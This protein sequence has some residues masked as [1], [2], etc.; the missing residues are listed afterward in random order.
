[1]NLIVRHGPAPCDT[2]DAEGVLHSK[3]T[4]FFVLSM[5]AADA[6]LAFGDDPK[7]L[8]DLVRQIWAHATKPAG[9]GGLGEGHIL[10]GS[11]TGF[12]YVVSS[13]SCG[14][15]TLG[16][17]DGGLPFVPKN[18]VPLYAVARYKK[19]ADCEDPDAPEFID[20]GIDY[21]GTEGPGDPKN[22][23]PTVFQ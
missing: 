5:T 16:V 6:E 17:T 11:Y 23:R 13:S 18:Y 2:E 21:R 8:V 15:E 3:F 10:V 19:P 7:P 22:L 1:M 9:E 12:E 14:G 4:G 20:L